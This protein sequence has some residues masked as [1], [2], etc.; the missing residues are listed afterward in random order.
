MASGL[1]LIRL[2]F[3]LALAAHGTQKLF[4]WFG[5]GGPRQTAG[6]FEKLEF[7]QPLAMAVLAGL[8]EL[9][10]G[11]LFAAGLLTPLAGFA[12]AVVML[13][14]IAT[15]HWSKGFWATNGGY[16][17]NLSII[18]AGIAVA[19]TGPGRYSLDNALGWTGGLSGA[20]WG[21][22]ALAAAAVATLIT[23]TLGRTHTLHAGP[24]TQGR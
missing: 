23:L 7:R 18:T 19:A 2:V 24:A 10:G 4:G 20:W 8:G 22:G 11:A 15:V 3:G 13:T 12:I 5:G 17:Y 6:F 14:A 16:E 9:G 1:L 21:A